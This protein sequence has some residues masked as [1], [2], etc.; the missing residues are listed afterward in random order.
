GI[1]IDT[2]VIRGVNDDELIDLV[3]YGRRI[4]GEVRFIEYMDVGGATHWS[5][6]QVVS[7]AEILRAL[8]QRYGGVEARREEASAPGGG[9]RLPAGTMCGVIRSTPQAFGQ[10]CDRSRRTADG[11]WY[12]CL[13]ATRGTRLGEALRRGADRQELAALISGTWRERADR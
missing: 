12:R 6:E 7:R 8:G 9:F 11:V 10:S 1:K 4:D 2:V 5:M 3:E 13:Y